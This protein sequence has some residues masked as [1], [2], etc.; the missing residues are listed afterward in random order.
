MIMRALSLFALL[1]AISP[2]AQAANG[3]PVVPAPGSYSFKGEFQLLAKKRSEAVY[4]FTREGAERLSLL[5]KMNYVCDNTGR[6]IYRCH[7]FESTEGNGKEVADRIQK[8]LKGLTLTFGEAR[9]EPTF[10]HKGWEYVEWQIPQTVT[11]KG[12]EYPFFRY[13]ISQGNQKFVFGEGEFGETVH[14]ND[15]GQMLYP[16]QLSKT[17]SRHVYFLYFGLGELAK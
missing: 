12:K 14:T 7:N 9:G 4:A 1:L 8:E 17:E 15:A 2:L 11:F 3:E 10:L 13:V 5:R 6:Q 16:L